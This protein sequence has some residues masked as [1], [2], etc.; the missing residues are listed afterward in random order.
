MNKLLAIVTTP[1]SIIAV[2]AILLLHFINPVE[3]PKLAAGKRLMSAIIHSIFTFS[4]CY[5]LYDI[6]R[7][8]WNRSGNYVS[9]QI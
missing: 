8:G 1:I 3:P 4:V 2:P 9:L 6:T 5:T 7:R